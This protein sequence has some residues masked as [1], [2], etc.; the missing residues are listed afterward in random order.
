LKE[1]K[2]DVLRL[3]VTMIIKTFISKNVLKQMQSHFLY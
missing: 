1:R 2:I 3:G